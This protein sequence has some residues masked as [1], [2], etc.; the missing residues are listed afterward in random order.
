MGD[1]SR[2]VQHRL[3]G[4]DDNGRARA[5]PDGE[6]VRGIAGIVKAAFA[7]L[8]DQREAF[9][10]PAQIGFAIAGEHFIEEAEMVHN[11]LRH[12][13]VGSS[14]QDNFSAGIF[15]FP[16]PIQKSILI[17]QGLGIHLHARG[18]F[19]LEQGASARPP[20]QNLEKG[21]RI[22]PQ[23]QRERFPHQVGADD[24]AIEVNDQRDVWSVGHAAGMLAE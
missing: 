5:A 18:Q 19:L 23:Q 24:G 10:F 12:A 9:V 2:F 21:Q 3:R 8:V 7:E 13:A 16:Q 22:P 17:G 20:E 14:G 4:V 15:F 11:R 1:F 6:V